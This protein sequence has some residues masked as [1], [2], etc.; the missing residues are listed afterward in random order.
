[1][2]YKRYREGFNTNILCFTTLGHDIK[3]LNT[4]PIRLVLNSTAPHSRRR[5]GTM[6]THA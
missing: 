2:E 1:M 5:K 6:L 3:P 4:K